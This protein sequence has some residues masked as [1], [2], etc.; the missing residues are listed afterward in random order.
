[1]AAFSLS[2]A[3][4]K[5]AGLDSRWLAAAFSKGRFATTA[6]SPALLNL[7]SDYLR[8]SDISVFM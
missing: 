2:H 7:R 3:L 1:M 6:P 8:E 5:P 4:P